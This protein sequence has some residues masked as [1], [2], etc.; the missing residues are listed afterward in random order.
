MPASVLACDCVSV[1]TSTQSSRTPLPLPSLTLTLT[2]LSRLHLCVC[3]CVC[4]CLYDCV[5]VLFVR[6]VCVY[7]CVCNFFVFAAQKY[8]L[9]TL[10]FHFLHVCVSICFFRVGKLNSPPYRIIFRFL[11][12]I[13]TPYIVA[14]LLASYF[15]LLPTFNYFVNSISY[16]YIFL[17]FTNNMYVYF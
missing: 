16:F 6:C 7:A 2:C 15:F 4:E 5:C 9:L 8:H 10:H 13:F 12:A 17:Y 11:F 14:R 3:V 1:R